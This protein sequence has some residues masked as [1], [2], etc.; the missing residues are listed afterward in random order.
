VKAPVRSQNAADLNGPRSA[1][2]GSRG[3]GSAPLGAGRTTVPLASGLRGLAGPRIGT[4]TAFVFVSPRGILGERTT[5]F[6]LAS[7]IVSAIGVGALYQAL[8]G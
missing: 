8:I 1:R 7:W 3:A 5:A 6:Y 2:A 4:L